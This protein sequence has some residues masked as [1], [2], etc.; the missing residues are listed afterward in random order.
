VETPERRG[1]MG[2]NAE[3]LIALIAEP[4]WGMPVRDMEELLNLGGDA[5]VPLLNLLEGSHLP[6]SGEVELLWAVVMLGE[7]RD[8]RAVPALMSVMRQAPGWELPVAAAEA[9]AKMGPGA[10]EALEGLL[11]ETPDART[12]ILIYAVLAQMG[13]PVAWGLLERALERDRELD[14]AVARALAER[15]SSE[16]QSR[17]YGVYA[18]TEPWKRPILEDT[19]EGMIG[20]SPTWGTRHGNWRIG[21]RRSPRQGLQIPFTWPAV[22][23]ALWEARAELSAMMQGP[24]ISWER[25]VDK[26]RLRVQQ[27]KCP[28][29]GEPFRSPTGI[30][31]CGEVEVDLVA[32]QLD[33]IQDWTADRWEDLYEVLDEL[34]CQ[35]MDALHLPEDTEEARRNKFEVLD[36]LEVVKDTVLWM[37]EQGCSSLSEGEKLIQAALSEARMKAS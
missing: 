7:L 36:S 10:L 34:D 9:L 8:R 19:L 25:I 17:V 35:E 27:E 2:L 23:L 12:R 29:C 20:H 32:F 11:A 24:P 16:D 30:P 21:Y 6:D 37:V 31:L 15:N 5:V 14:F 33:R 18:R 13:L 4:R 28:D 1:S 26:A 22:M 3:Q